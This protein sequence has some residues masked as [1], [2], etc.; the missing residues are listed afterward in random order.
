MQFRFFLRNDFGLLLL[1]F[2]LLTLALSSFGYFLSTFMRRTQS[3]TYTG[4]AVFLVSEI[5]FSFFWTFFG[6][7]VI[8]VVLACYCGAGCSSDCSGSLESV[9]ACIAAA[10]AA[11]AVLVIKSPG[12]SVAVAAAAATLWLAPVTPLLLLLLSV[13][14]RVVCGVLQVGWICQTVIVFGVPYDPETYFAPSGGGVCVSHTRVAFA[15]AG[16]EACVDAAP[17]C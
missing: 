17:A 8:V 13:V 9:T 12:L 11:G 4:F 7:G 16:R 15:F 6:T 5:V 2:W 14:C 1:L 10:T 3:A